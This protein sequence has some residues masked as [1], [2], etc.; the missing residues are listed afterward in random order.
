MPEPA[1][2]VALVALNRPGYR[3]LALGYLHGGGES[4]IFNVGYGSGFS[5]KEVVKVAEEVCGHPI[6]VRVGPR[7]AG[8]P[9]ALVAD[10]ARLKARL[11]WKPEH[12]DLKTIVRSAYEW[13]RRLTVAV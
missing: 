4:A 1:L 7:R 9:P 6:P 2:K 13:E 8:D 3:S 12:D 11:G 10:S 5:V